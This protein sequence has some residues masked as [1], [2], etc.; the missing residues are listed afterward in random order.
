MYALSSAALASA[1][2]RVCSSGSVFACG[3]GQVPKYLPRGDYKWGGCADNIRFG[4]R[5]SK[6]FAD[7]ERFK[8]KSDNKKSLRS[9]V[10]QH[11]SRAG[12]KVNRNI[13]LLVIY[14]FDNIV[15]S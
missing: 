3:C 13:K 8:K 6:N 12:R 11:N 14:I 15:I 2:A 9:L 10:H 4:L 1:V 5:F 7:F